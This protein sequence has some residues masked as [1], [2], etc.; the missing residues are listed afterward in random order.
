MEKTAVYPGTFDPVTNGHVDIIR[1]AVRMFD[2]V[3]VALANNPEK[4]PLFDFDER[5]RLIEE[6]I[7]DLD[8]V[9]V[10]AFQTLLVDYVRKQKSDVIIRG[11]RAF[12]DFDY[13]YQ[14]AMMNRSL[15]SDIETVFMLPSEEYTYVSSRLIKEVA[16]LGGDVGHL[17]P[18]VVLAALKDKL[19]TGKEK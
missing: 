2:N 16:G 15:D 11:V 10:D 17:V 7:R 4:K 6:S 18:P 13:E 8:N 14:M 12:T 9:R 1:R 3:V 19:A 5:K